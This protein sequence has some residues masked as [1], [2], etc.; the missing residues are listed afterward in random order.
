MMEGRP[1]FDRIICRACGA[2]CPEPNWNRRAPDAQPEPA[3]PMAVEP[4]AHTTQWWMHRLDMEKTQAWQQG[5]AQGLHRATP[6][7]A[8][9]DGGRCGVGGYCAKCP[10]VHPDPVEWRTFVYNGFIKFDIG[11]QTFR[12]AYAAD[13]HLL[14][15]QQAAQLE[16]VRSML[17]AA[18]SRLSA[19]PP[20]AALTEQDANN[21]ALE[22]VKGGKSVQW[23]IRQVEA[24]HGIGG[25]RNE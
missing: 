7:Q 11:N 17:H 9:C 22:V 21:L 14:P 10:A 24:A 2:M 4:T 12:L 19:T 6:L 16:W 15:S 13:D 5:Y 25:P 18:L 1:T 3:A 23:L 20:R 8:P